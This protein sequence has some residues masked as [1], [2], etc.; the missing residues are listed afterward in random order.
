[1]Y[2]NEWAKA[3]TNVPANLLLFHRL[4]PLCLF[5]KVHL[6]Q[7]GQTRAILWKP[8]GHAFGC[9]YLCSAT[10]WRKSWRYLAKYVRNVLSDTEIDFRHSRIQEIRK[11]AEMKS[12]SEMHSRVWEC[13]VSAEVSWCPLMNSHQMLTKPT[14]AVDKMTS[15]RRRTFPTSFYQLESTG[16]FCTSGQ[17]RPLYC[18]LGVFLV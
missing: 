2:A 4:Q 6:T 14:H 3:K 7:Y 9:W 15:L 13:I 5:M 17:R 8:H 16:L 12:M 18:N 11:R 10:A 1:M